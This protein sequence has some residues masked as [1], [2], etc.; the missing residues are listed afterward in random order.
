MPDYK[1]FV[2]F[3]VHRRARRNKIRNAHLT[4]CAHAVK[5]GCAKTALVVIQSEESLLI[6]NK[7]QREILHAKRATPNDVLRIFFGYMKARSAIST[8]VL[9]SLWKRT[10]RAAYRT[11]NKSLDAVCTKM[12]HL[13]ERWPS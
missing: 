10:D 12:K 9:K 7:R 1:S 3:H 11:R 8:V 4:P 13:N 2:W 5:P 6:Q